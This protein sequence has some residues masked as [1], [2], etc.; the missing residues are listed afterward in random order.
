MLV[1]S[2]NATFITKVN[3]LTGLLK[4]RSLTRAIIQIIVLLSLVNL[5]GCSS[6]PFSK[7]FSGRSAPK[8]DSSI[9]VIGKGS[10]RVALLLPLSVTGETKQIGQIYRNSAELALMQST[11]KNIQ[12]LII[13]TNATYLGGSEAARKAISSGA[14]LILG[15][16]FTPAVSGATQ[17]AR[18]QNIPIIAFTQYIDNTRPGVY[19]LD[20]VI[21][22]DIRRII[23][24][25]VSKGKENFAAIL[26]NNDF[27]TLVEESFQKAVTDFDGKINTVFFYN[28]DPE[29][30]LGANEFLTIADNLKSIVDKVD[31]VFLPVGGNAAKNLAESL[32]YFNI[33]NSQIQI[34]GTGSWNE[35]GVNNSQSLK[36][37]WFPAP[38]NVNF[39]KFSQQYFE[40]YEAKPPRNATT[41]YDAILLAVGL[42]NKQDSNQFN[43]QTLTNSVGFRGVDG[44]F[45]FSS[46]GSIERG[47]AV[48]QINELA[49][50]IIDPAPNLFS[51]PTN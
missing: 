33:N 28:L 24:Y 29:T 19:S 49:P 27:G 10:V 6:N 8:I 46:D 40:L 21:Y 11:S 34:L 26:P 20:S 14:E 25:S 1:N 42:T 51:N 18:F 7:L 17:V 23:S 4:M 36:G 48:Y 16:V 15:P 32:N 39:F 38:T 3:F 22:D 45:R 5:S 9:E 37:A 43:H 47:L 35:D 31:A 2:I 12:L 44:I 50:Q 13:N 41:A 30:K